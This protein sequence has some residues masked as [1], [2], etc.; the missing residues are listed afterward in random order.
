MNY[1]ANSATLTTLV[2]A[3]PFMSP[4]VGK[5]NGVSCVTTWWAHVVATIQRNKHLPG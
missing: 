5:A 2:P 3:M 1:L 4:F